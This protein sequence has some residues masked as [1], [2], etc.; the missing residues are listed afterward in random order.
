M[1]CARNGFTFRVQC[2]TYQQKQ[3]ELI[4]AAVGQTQLLLR[5]KFNQF[6]DVINTR[7]SQM[8]TLN[9]FLNTIHCA[10]VVQSCITFQH[11]LPH[12]QCKSSSA[13]K[14]HKFL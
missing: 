3:I 10:E 6:R 2:M 5:C 7:A 11:N 4:S 14:V 8:K 9:I 13:Y 1:A 12:A